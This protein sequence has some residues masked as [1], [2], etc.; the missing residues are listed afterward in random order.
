M[1]KK[2]DRCPRCG[3][4]RVAEQVFGKREELEP[5]WLRGVVFIG[6][7]DRPPPGFDHFGCLE[8]GYTWGPSRVYLHQKHGSPC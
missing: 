5:Y 2:S 1:P 4:R 8:C 6:E 7:G 3:S